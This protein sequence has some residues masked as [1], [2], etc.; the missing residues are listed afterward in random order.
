MQNSG[1]ATALVNEAQIV[2]NC[3]NSIQT[4]P[5]QPCPPLQKYSIASKHLGCGLTLTE[6]LARHPDIAWRTAQRLIA[7]L[8]ESGQTVIQTEASL[9]GT[10]T[11]SFPSFIPLSADSQDILAYINQPPDVR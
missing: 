2:K 1:T 5:L 10:E 7:K 3:A 8:I 9:Q 11:D 4:A 6:L